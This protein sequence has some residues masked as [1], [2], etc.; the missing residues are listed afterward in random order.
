MR[1]LIVDTDYPSFLDW[2]YAQ[3]PGLEHK[4]YEQQMQA[5]AESLFG[6]GV[7]YASNLRKLGHEAHQIFF[8]NEDLQQAWA[9]EHGL[10][11]N[12]SWRFRLR[13]GL[14]PWL[15]RSRDPDWLYDILT[16]QIKYY[17][18]DVLLNN[19]MR[20]STAY[21]RQ[22]KPYLRLLVGS[23]GSPMP[24]DRDFGVYDLVLSVVENFVDYFRREGLHSELLRLGFEPRILERFN[25]TERS[26]PVSFVGQLSQH[27][28]SRLHWLE[29]LCQRVPGQV[30]APSTNGLPDDSPVHRCHRGTVW[31]I[32][33]YEI[34]Y[35][36][37]MTLNHHID[38]A[39][40]YAGNARLFEATG[41]GTLLVTDWKKNLH[42]MFEP[43][44][45]VVAYRSAEECTE[46]V[47]Y[48]LEHDKEREA[49]ARAGQQRTLRHHTFYDR[50]QEFADTV[51]KYL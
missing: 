13:R 50:M 11:I 31:G 44:K 37:L 39:G 8:N 16:S 24:E 45:E 20:L 15:S 42:E 36:S 22:M 49:I 47:Q 10:K 4:T 27:H 46:M 43:G 19:A 38:V 5:R 34:F 6:C 23:H 14:V 9:R 40:E 3:D 35:K 26:I 48:Y 7:S 12:K 30:W 21:F 2:L 17:K 33:M 25:G 1:F 51:Q 32:E 28:A 29:Y 41:V 18:P